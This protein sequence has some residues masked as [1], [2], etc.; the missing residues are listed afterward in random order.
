MAVAG[1]A[2]PAAR[3]GGQHAARGRS[4]L[5]LLPKATATVLLI[6]AR[7]LL[8]VSA[9][10]PPLKGRGCARRCRTSSRII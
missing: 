7:D 10:V 3:Q 9:T 4:A 8:T 5:G 1:T 6:A 2:V